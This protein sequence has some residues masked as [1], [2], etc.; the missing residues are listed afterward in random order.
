MKKV[1]VNGKI[2]YTTSVIPHSD[3]KFPIWFDC[4]NKYP[5]FINAELV[6]F[7]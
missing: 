5:D 7:L 3:D 2:G 4:G 1:I 6:V